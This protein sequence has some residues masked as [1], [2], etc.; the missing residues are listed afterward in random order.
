[1]HMTIET[2]TAQLSGHVA[3]AMATPLTPDG[4]RLNANVIPQLVDFLIERGVGGLFV[5]GTTGEGILLSDAE[6]RQLHALSVSAAAR[7]VPVLLHVGTNDTQSAVALAQHA[8]SIGADAI[9]AVTP[10]FYGVSDEA[11]LTHFAAIA[12]A[13]PETPFF[14]YDIPQMAV[15]GISTALAQQ[16]I[17]D[18]P[19]FA[20]VKC[21]R[22][23]MQAIR[24]LIDAVAD[25]VLILAGNEPIMLGS[26]ALGAHG[27]ISG[28]ATAIPEPFV[29]LLA[30][31]AAGNW[32]AARQQQRLINRLLAHMAAGPRIGNIKAILQAR[33][34]PVNR[35]MP[36][37]SPGSAELWDELQ[38]IL[39]NP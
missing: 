26:L 37:R 1:M 30:A 32:E 17:A 33:G 27:A 7:R 3:P 19:T 34:V 16:M 5:G 10:T 36:P 13:A 18:I 15:N 8:A 39:D 23:D 24:R 22:T 11:L 12:G 25:S 20:G 4:F 29:A 2:L 6:R 21:S 38:L 35:P 9:V 31:F 28:L 14:A